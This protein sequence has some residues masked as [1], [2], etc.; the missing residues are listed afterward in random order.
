MEDVED[1][2]RMEKREKMADDI[3]SLRAYR[4]KSDARAFARLVGRYAGLVY[5]AAFR[6][7]GN[8]EDA[9]D[10]LQ[11]TFV[12][13]LNKFPG[14][15]LTAS[16]TTFLYPVVK[17]TSLAVL[18][19]KRKQADAPEAILELPT[20]AKPDSEQGARSELAIVLAALPEGQR[21]VLLMRFVDGMTINEIA[22]ALAIPPGT[23]KSRLHNALNT[24]REDD[25]TRSYFEA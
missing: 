23:V 20:A 4:E 16:M 2:R 3:E 21:E 6:V 12:Y 11:E 18:R 9:L 19:K 17:N 1:G 14:F 15:R 24:L 7:T 22:T 13:L 25:R 5:G 10:V 8:R